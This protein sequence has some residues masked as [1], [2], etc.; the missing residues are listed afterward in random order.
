MCSSKESECVFNVSVE[1][2][3]CLV[4]CEGIFADVT[5]LKAPEITGKYYE[6]LLRSY[7]KYKRFFDISD[8]K[9]L[10]QKVCS[11]SLIFS[12]YQLPSKLRFVNIYFDTPTFDK[13]TKDRSA[14][15][16]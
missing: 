6:K 8:C 4:P 15:E 13:I 16:S 11:W 1:T 10:S 3:N 2:N 7:D 9:N 14:K 5:K 12:A